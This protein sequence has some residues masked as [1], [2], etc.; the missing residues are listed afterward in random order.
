M[1]FNKS[2]I[3]DKKYQYKFINN[4]RNGK[5]VF[6]CDDLILLKS[7]VLNLTLPLPNWQLIFRTFQKK[8]LDP[9]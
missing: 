6:R 8:Y 9:F 3:L 4:Q 5:E 2:P 7:S 1:A